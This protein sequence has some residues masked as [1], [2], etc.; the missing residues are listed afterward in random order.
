[1]PEKTPPHRVCTRCGYWVLAEDDRYCSWCSARLVEL[2]LEPDSFLLFQKR[3]SDGTR[4]LRLCNKGQVPIISIDISPDVEWIEAEPGSV[5]VLEPEGEVAIELRL[6]GD[7]FPANYQQGVV[8][9]TSGDGEVGSELTADL[10][11][12]VGLIERVDGGPVVLSEGEIERV[13]K[14]RAQRGLVDVQGVRVAEADWLRVRPVTPLPMR[15]TSELGNTLELRATID[16]GLLAREVAS[17]AV[18]PEAGEGDS[19]GVKVRM[20]LVADLPGTVKV[21]PFFEVLRP[22][23]LQLSGVHETADTQVYELEVEEIYCG[24][25]R[26]VAVGIRNRGDQELAVS[27]I[28]VA[29]N[30]EFLK[31]SSGGDCP[32]TVKPHQSH[33]FDLLIDVTAAAA[34]ETQEGSIRIRSNSFPAGDFELF[35]SAIPD[36]MPVF[37]G[38]IGVDYGTTNSCVAYQ[39]GLGEPVMVPIERRGDTA[40]DSIPSV[41]LYERVAEPAKR[42]YQV[43]T[44]AKSIMG[45]AGAAQSVI[46]SAKR[47]IG[48]GK[49]YTV[50]GFTD[51]AKMKLTAEE[52]SSDTVR[53]ILRRTEL[54]LRQRVREVAIT[55]PA[56]FAWAQVEALKAAFQ[57]SDREV[58][59]ALAEPVAAGLDFIIGGRQRGAYSLLVL[60]YGGGTTDVSLF[61]VDAADG[62]IA[63]RLLGTDTKKNFGG[64]DVTRAVV[65]HFH[66]Q[67][68]EG[69]EA[70][71]EGVPLVPPFE[72]SAARSPVVADI[73]VQN[74]GTLWGVAEAAKIRLS[75]E[76]D[77]QGFFEQMLG[78]ILGSDGSPLPTTRVEIRLGEIHEAVAKPT[79]AVIAMADA[80]VRLCVDRGDIE[81]VGHV[82]L[83]GNA[84]QLPLVRRQVAEAYPQAEL[85]AGL[86]AT[87]GDD[88][89]DEDIREGDGEARGRAAACAAGATGLKSCVA[90]GACRAQMV[91]GG[92]GAVLDLKGIDVAT[93]RIGLVVM[94]PQP[95]FQPV[96]EL[97]DPLGEWKRVDG[98][99]KE[100]TVQV[101]ESSGGGTYKKL[102]HL[103]AA[104]LV[105][106][107]GESV[108]VDLMLTD[109][110]EVR[111]RL[112]AD[113]VEPVDIDV[114]TLL[115]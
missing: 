11:P 68:V 91:R 85:I 6:I 16:Q 76:D 101:V 21:D 28:E 112:S 114:G 50:R 67:L 35:V 19:S 106:T 12:E 2:V 10:Y 98:A 75:R 31:L 37:E 40:A 41:V 83:T 71:A 115:A 103:R 45:A 70:E 9:V 63:P 22:P 56:R 104:D 8:S 30:A 13:V 65:D 88:A 15:L 58:V 26:R 36:S 102:A 4:E 25:V 72:R 79:R 66:R 111:A 23:L 78:N 109:R 46:Q 32:V 57:E 93:S 64:D 86:P 1:M 107:D 105:T 89:G 74:W 95:R 92:M 18:I 43:G 5:A 60:D 51:K 84:S 55:Y 39:S 3:D 113:G 29:G 33:Q 90:R 100:A 7:R 82:L 52:V 27:G 24:E 96:I 20:E 14:F 49:E 108:A 110:H 73:G 87:D 69:A 77:E 38:V 59:L 34:C 42:D 48:S 99:T 80:L 81:G 44:Y 54:H 62:R 97:G 47:Q 94:D 61:L 53:D 17:G